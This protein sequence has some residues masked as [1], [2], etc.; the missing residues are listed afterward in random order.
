MARYVADFIK[1]AKQFHNL[2]IRYTGVWNERP[3]DPAYVKLLH[4]TLLSQ[5]ISTKIV[6]CDDY[7]RDKQF[8]IIHAMQSDA[9][10]A[11]S[12]AV[13]G[14]HYPWSGSADGY[15]TTPQDKAS[16]KTLW[17]SED[18]P[19][20]GGGP[21]LSR[22]WKSGGRILAQV[23]N[24]N[25]L[26]GAFT[27]TEIW[28]PITSY[29]EN[30]AAP[31]SG[32]MIANT[33]WSGHYVVESTIW[34]TAHTTQFADPG[35]QY[36]DSASGF[37]PEKQGSYVALKSPRSHDWSVIVETIDSH[38][39]QSVNFVLK[40]GLSNSTVHIW[41]TNASKIFAHV[42]DVTPRDNRFSYTFEPDSLYSLTTRGGQ[43]KGAAQ[44]PPAKSFPMPYTEN[45][46]QTLLNKAP[47]YLADQD[48]AFEVHP[49]RQRAGRCLEQMITQKPIPWDPLPDPFTLTGDSDRSDYHVS[50]DVLPITA[51]AVTLMGR[52]DSADVFRDAKA[53]WPSGYVLQV[54]KDGGW[55]LIS[56][57]YKMP[58]RV[59]AS[60]S[61][62]ALSGWHQLSLTFRNN[63]ITAAID[64][65]NVAAVHYAAHK[66]GMFAVGTDW[67]RAQ[68]DNLRVSP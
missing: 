7:R 50:A 60:G 54:R 3:Y 30:L 21:F 5:G 26:E 43:G 34:V 24:R 18:Q 68:F 59:L 66:A 6:C 55:R 61:I 51:N 16:G 36:M 15:S 48:G 1:G 49:C 65:K 41:E 35:W 11:A 20:P 29:F 28:S 23:Y 64:G 47:K 9:E 56:A 58:V 27:K 33:P 63:Q 12:V 8:E 14:I 39:P 4:R 37:F 44:P 42:A 10:L 22:E 62:A 38:A 46:E 2:D 45:F 25:Y 19:N 17:S 40:N 32:L 31:H 13:V 53:L 57:A 52:I 67:G